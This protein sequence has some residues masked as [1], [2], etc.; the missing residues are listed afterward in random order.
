MIVKHLSPNLAVFPWCNAA[1]GGAK[2]IIAK[3]L[4][5]HVNKHSPNS[6]KENMLS[7]LTGLGKG[8]CCILLSQISPEGK[9]LLS[10]IDFA[11]T[12]WRLQ[13]CQW[14][15][16]IAGS[17][18]PFSPIQNSF[19]QEQHEIASTGKQI[20][21]VGRPEVLSQSLLCFRYGLC[22]LPEIS[23]CITAE[24]CLLVKGL[25]ATDSKIMCTIYS[26]AGPLNT[27]TQSHE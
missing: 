10:E 19:S 15:D 13:V 5:C 12:W 25:N 27:W 17:S 21:M 14:R 16:I 23:K 4:A 22:C 8:Y 9:V 24:P 26:T 1:M 18:A 7:L 20:V 11:H 2:L 3:H 6:W